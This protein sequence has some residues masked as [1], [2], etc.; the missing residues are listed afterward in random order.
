MIVCHSGDV[1]CGWTYSSLMG[2]AHRKSQQGHCGNSTIKS[3]VTAPMG[4]ASYS[5]AFML[6]IANS[7]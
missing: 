2:M 5:M 6:T 1:I 3:Q 4:K 7:L